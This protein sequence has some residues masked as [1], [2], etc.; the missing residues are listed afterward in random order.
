MLAF[1]ANA[2][3]FL[4]HSPVSM[5]KSFEG[6]SAA[7]EQLFPEELLSGALF[8]FLNKRRDHL[9]ILFGMVTDWSFISNVLKKVPIFG[10][11]AA[12]P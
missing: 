3:I 6:L 4:Y 8:V 9:K 12:L 2:R 5:R 10:S 11:G 1:P 7:V